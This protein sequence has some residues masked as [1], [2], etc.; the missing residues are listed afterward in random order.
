MDDYDYVD[1][2]GG[3]QSNE[4]IS[5]SVSRPRKR[6]NKKDEAAILEEGIIFRRVRIR[7]ISCVR[8]AVFKRRGAG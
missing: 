1:V 8:F 3:I 6:K 2:E 7:W 5:A 4:D